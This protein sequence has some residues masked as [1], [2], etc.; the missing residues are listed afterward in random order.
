M[1][2]RFQR[3]FTKPIPDYLPTLFH[4]LVWLAYIG[5][6]IY[7]NTYQ[8]VNFL[9]GHPS[10]YILAQMIVFYT[11]YQY[12]IPALLARMK[13]ARFMAVNGLLILGLVSLGIPA[14]QG[15][16]NWYLGGEAGHFPLSYR[17]QFI[18]RSLELVLF[19]A[20][21]CIVRFAVD[22]F[23]FQQK[24][25]ELE[26]TQLRTELSFLRS[27]LNPHFLF[28]TLNALYG[29]AIKQSADTSAG[30]MQLSQLMRYVLYETDEEQVPLEKE[31]E[32]IEHFL[33]LQRL[34]LPLDFPL[35]FVVQGDVETVRLEPLLLLP[36]VE[37]V[38]KHGAEFA[39]I[40]LVL[41]ETSLTLRTTNGIRTTGIQPVGGIGLTNLKRR[42][43]H[44][45]E[46][47]HQLQL[48]QT[49]EHFQTT[50]L[51]TFQRL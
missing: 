10:V 36:I 39:S 49:G 8:G 41:D 34:R 3:L 5:S 27:Q 2:H 28:N 42:L 37:N 32:M 47:R 44:L 43:T 46:N 4:S 33:A 14:Y 7:I 1:H 22:W 48:S 50:L 20:L 29:L 35:H 18:L 31:V 13:V 19:V 16:R 9:I 6:V 17:E 45:Y 12:F 38:F 11:N 25:R 40:S 15:L 51:L 21:A 30:I 26:N 23:T 24:R